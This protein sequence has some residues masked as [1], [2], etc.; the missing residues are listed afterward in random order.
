MAETAF[1]TWTPDLFGDCVRLSASAASATASSFLA[2]TAVG[3]F[4]VAAG[5]AR[6]HRRVVRRLDVLAVGGWALMWTTTTTII[7]PAGTHHR[8]VRRRRSVASGIGA[9]DQR[10]QPPTRPR[11][12]RWPWARCRK[13]C[14]PVPARCCHGSQWHL[15][16]VLRHVIP[17]CLLLAIATTTGAAR[18]TSLRHAVTRVSP[19]SGRVLPST[20][21]QLSGIAGCVMPGPSAARSG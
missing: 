19:T 12:A 15:L 16:S 5:A 17:A 8:R 10:V 18:R 13:R 9:A 6:L 3:W 21:T 20:P 1:V 11:S 7:A 2:G 4:T 14:R